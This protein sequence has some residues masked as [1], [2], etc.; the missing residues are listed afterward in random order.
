MAIVETESVVPPDAASG[1]LEW[2]AA[3]IRRRISAQLPFYLRRPG[4]PAEAAE[5]SV[6]ARSADFPSRDECFDGRAIPNRASQERFGSF[7]R[8]QRPRLAPGQAAG[9]ARFGKFLEDGLQRYGEARNDP[10]AGGES[11]M[12]PYLHFGQVSP[13]SLAWLALERSETAAQPYVEQ[14]VVRR[15]LALN[16]A[17]RCPG[18]DRYETAVPDWARASLAD[19]AGLSTPYS[20][21]DL[22]AG[23]TED[24]YWNAAQKEMILTGKMHNYMRMYWGKRLLAWFEN[25]AEAFQAAIALNDTY[26]LDGRDPN[27]YAGVAWCFGRHDRPWPQR[28][29][30]GS[31]RAM[32]ASGLRRKFD[33]DR[34]ASTIEALY[35]ERIKESP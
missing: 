33:I 16:F 18:Y 29:G 4:R 24:P 10:L 8:L 12:S 34:Y 23:R 27:G 17:L 28:A 9:M 20:L 2:S 5:A 13:V 21:A 26:S 32:M 6:A 30:F 7:L 1:K 31:V 35:T 3:T 15:E 25:P 11:G 14:L 19:R 22:E